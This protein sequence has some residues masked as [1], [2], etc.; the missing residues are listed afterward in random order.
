MLQYLVREQTYRGLGADE[1]DRTAG[2][3]V[4]N[5]KEQFESKTVKLYTRVTEYQ[6]RLARQYASN[7]FERYLRNTLKLDGWND[8]LDEVKKFE[9]QASGDIAAID[10]IRLKSLV[11][12]QKKYFEALEERL[13]I[14]QQE[15]KNI[16]E[17]IEAKRI[18]DEKGKEEKERMRMRDEEVSKCLS[19]I[20]QAVPQLPKPVDYKCTVE[21][22]KGKVLPDTCGWLYSHATYSEF[23]SSDGNDLLWINGNPGKGKSMLTLS[24]IDKLTPPVDTAVTD[25]RKTICC[26][27][28]F[29]HDDYRMG[30]SVALM[31]SILYQL[32]ESRPDLVVNIMQDVEIKQEELF[33]QPEA[34]EACWR[35]LMDMV[36][37]STAFGTLYLIIDGL[38]ECDSESRTAWLKKLVGDFKPKQQQ[39]Q[40]RH[41]VKW[42]ITSRS[43]ELD[44]SEALGNDSGFKSICLEDNTTAIEKDVLSYIEAQKQTFPKRFDETEKAIISRYLLENSEGTFL[45]VWLACEQIRKARPGFVDAVIKRPVKGLD[46]FYQRMLESIDEDAQEKARDVLQ[47]VLYA[48]RPLILR[49][50]AIA[51]NIANVDGDTSDDR[52]MSYLESCGSFVVIEPVTGVVT[53]IHRSARTFLVHNI[54]KEALRNIY[55]ASW[56]PEEAHLVLT[57]RSYGYLHSGALIACKSEN[58][59]RSREDEST[60]IAATKYPFLNYA[61]AFWMYHARL[62]DSEG[63]KAS[64]VW[65][66]ILRSCL[67]WRLGSHRQHLPIYSSQASAEE[68]RISTSLVILKLFYFILDICL[69]VISTSLVSSK[70]SKTNASRV[71]DIFHRDDHFFKTDSEIRRLWC[72]Q[73]AFSYLNWAKESYTALQVASR[74]GIVPLVTLLLDCNHAIDE[75]DKAGNTALHHAVWEGN[76]DVVTILL[77]RGANKESKDNKGRTVLYL[78]A[79]RGHHSTAKI[80][81][82]GIDNTLLSTAETEHGQTPLHIAVDSLHE[83]VAQALVRSMNST[84][85]SL[86][87]KDKKRHTPLHY[88]ACWGYRNVTR[89]QERPKSRGGGTTCASASSMSIGTLKEV[90]APVAQED[91]E[92]TRDRNFDTFVRLLL[93]NG[94]NVEAEDSF[95][96]KTLHLATFEQ[97]ESAIRI[98]LEVGKCNPSPRDRMGWTPLMWAADNSWIR[99]ANLFL[100][101]KADVSTA[102][103]KGQTA[104]HLAAMEKNVK[105]ISLLLESGA[106]ACAAEETGA[107]P[108]YISCQHGP[109]EA[110]RLMITSVKKASD[111]NLP[112]YKSMDTPLLAA[113]HRRSPAADLLLDAGCNPMLANKDGLNPLHMA[114]FRDCESIARKLLSLGADITLRTVNEN[115][116]PLQ[117]AVYKGPCVAELLIDAGSDLQVLDKSGGTLLHLASHS[118]HPGIVKKLLEKGLNSAAK[119]TAGATPLHEAVRAGSVPVAT[120]LVEAG[121]D[122]KVVCEEYGGT[123]LDIAKNLVQQSEETKQK[124][125]LNEYEEK[126]LDKYNA[127]VEYLVGLEGSS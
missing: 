127:L 6:I 77:N 110:A 21:S 98:L 53:L 37:S 7:S 73:Y 43:N 36:R 122:A 82:D 34:L 26:Y 105:M 111:L 103:Q 11:A 124:H 72:R 102:D 89:F 119:D 14:N 92:S 99:I 97:Q 106:D 16:V 54:K 5:L 80:L 112:F 59:V 84:S 50:L 120:L 78:A 96:Y 114:A 57:N 108:L 30:T 8:M 1:V 15:M 35:I 116:T 44:I 48:A 93:E 76:D 121:A 69:S 60:A 107:T 12:D 125:P 70:A 66:S 29:A 104:L 58:M 27:F 88:A 52:M 28:F 61:I 65:S 109:V 123:A 17:K 56:Q 67:T 25:E 24:L 22:K 85:S 74:G 115:F 75:T 126:S 64:S 47:A 18:A 46:E 71:A 41:K 118:N 100:N 55:A 62:A 31:R 40:S 83:D 68:S 51:S 86:D 39:Q 87:P 13:K 45:Y 23:T 49:E 2:I 42:I 33:T 32:L 38:D 10:S 19:T 20:I 81:L 101:F 79:L 4:A 94:A 113:I 9:A 91:D 90:L 3:N 117:M 63:R 95:G